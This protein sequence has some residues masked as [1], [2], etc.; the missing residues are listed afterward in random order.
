MKNQ[1]AVIVP[2]NEATATL[3]SCSGGRLATGV[4]CPLQPQGNC[5]TPNFVL[6]Q[7]VQTGF[8]FLE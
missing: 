1:E 3:H 6:T 2:S 8:Q 5:P 7:L 4:M